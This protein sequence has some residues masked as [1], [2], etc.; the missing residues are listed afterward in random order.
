V[1]PFGLHISPRRRQQ[2]GYPED[3]DN[4]FLQN[5]IS[6]QQTT[7]RHM[8]VTSKLA[9]K[10]RNRTNVNCVNISSE[11][12]LSMFSNIF[13]NHTQWKPMQNV[14]VVTK[15]H[16]AAMTEPGAFTFTSCKEKEG[17]SWEVEAL[18]SFECLTQVPSFIRGWS[19]SRKCAHWGGGGLTCLE[20]RS[21]ARDN[22]ASFSVAPFY[23]RRLISAGYVTIGFIT[24]TFSY[25]NWAAITQIV[26]NG[27]LSE[28]N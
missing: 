21:D 27:L 11:R 22:D 4:R 15:E 25:M 20:H 9:C 17:S 7:R 18:R 26:I 23:T 12:R 8:A 5:V 24:T 13:S 6:Y 10:V 16:R 19:V 3:G 1:K 28:S 14:E 2:A